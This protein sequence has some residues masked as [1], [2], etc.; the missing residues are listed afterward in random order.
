MRIATFLAI[1]PVGVLLAACSGGLTGQA[2]DDFVKITGF[3]N[4]GASGRDLPL[5]VAGNPFEMPGDSFARAVEA[6]V[7]VQTNRPPTHATLA[8]GPSARKGYSLTFVFEPA[9]T[10]QG[11][12]ICQGNFEQDPKPLLQ[13]MRLRR[14]RMIGAFCLSGRALTEVSGEAALAGTDDPA[15]TDFL[16]HAVLALFRPDIADSGDSGGR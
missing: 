9:R 2:S 7:Q 14:M 13:H 3:Y 10:L 16:H 6:A 8:P 5:K 15:F 4:Y 12:D 11:D 1:L